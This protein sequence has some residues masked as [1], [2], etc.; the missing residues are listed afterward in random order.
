MTQNYEKGIFEPLAFM[1]KHKFDL[2]FMCGNEE[3]L[4][5]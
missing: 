3:N 5:P 2:D 1:C 4:S